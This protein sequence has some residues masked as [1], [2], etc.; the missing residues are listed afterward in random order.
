MFIITVL[1]AILGLIATDIFVP[2]LPAI[3]QAFH[4]SLN[5]TE[6]TV[7]LF[8]VGFSFSQLVYGPISD[9]VGRKPPLMVGAI[10]FV[11]GSFIC[12]IA[13]TFVIF[14]LG[15]IIQ[16]IAVGSGLSIAR[17]ILRDKYAGKELAVKVSQLAIFVSLTPAI[18][19]FLGGV[20]QQYFGYKAVFIF[21]LAYGLLLVALL[22][23]CFTE[24]I[25]HK[26]KDLSFSHVILHYGQ[27]L[28][29]FQFMRYVIISG[30]AFGAIIL[31]ANILPFI[32]QNQLHLSAKQ[33]GDV[34]LLAA[35]G[36]CLG[37]FISSK[38]VH[39][40]SPTK[41][42]HLGLSILTLSGFLLVLC[43]TLFGASLLSLI[44]LIF[45]ITL[46]CGFIFPNSVALAFSQ[47]DVKIGIAGAVY[48][49]VQI[50]ISMML[51]FLLNVIP[52]QG[53]TL[54]GV[55]Y[56]VMG[57]AG[58]GLSWNWVKAR[59]AIQETDA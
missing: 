34:L 4:Q 3:G 41:L 10:L 48:G 56:I 42:V 47:I 18:A 51:N 19:P 52:D 54:L 57:L 15:R 53:Q 31:Y 39:R 5:H 40:Y 25:K 28:K 49:F 12:V 7:S 46:S 26:H 16:G 11:I 21:L 35:L 2:S 38:T 8:L 59:S 55:F 45:L 14:C 36:L 13:P 6:L 9:R 1:L 37:S 24:T 30:F 29:N 17:V 44:P 27:L 33:N 23:F 58:L 50:F 22:S 32:I 43:E 20:L